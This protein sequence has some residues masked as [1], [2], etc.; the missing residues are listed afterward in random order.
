[1][2]RIE[3]A[4]SLPQSRHD[5]PREKLERL[6]VS[7]LGDNELLAI[8]IGHGTPRHDALATA[9]AVLR[10]AGN[11]VGLTR[12]THEDLSRTAGVGAAVASRIQASV[13][14]GRRTLNANP[15][16]RP[17]LR[18]PREMA[19]WLMPRYGSA[20]VERFGVVLLDARHRVMRARLLSVGGVD[21]SAAVPRDIFREAITARASAL[22]LFHNHPSGDPVPSEEDLHLTRRLVSAGHV[23]GVEVVDHLIL[24]DMRYCSLKEAGIL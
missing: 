9:N 10:Q 11:I 16:H 5:R 15:D 7:A 20:P 1:M 14:L 18:S 17:R 12:L 6:G 13:E 22:A 23:V 3:S 19:L 24:A 21:V 2:S 4:P 8:I